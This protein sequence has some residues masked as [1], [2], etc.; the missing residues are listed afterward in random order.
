[1]NCIDPL[2][3]VGTF[4]FQ[5]EFLS[6]IS[7]ERGYRKQNSLFFKASEYS[8]ECLICAKHHAADLLDND[9]WIKMKLHLQN[10]QLTFS[11][12]DTSELSLLALC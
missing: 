3:T 12:Q 1:M 9:E 5:E 8:T 4:C 7:N 2:I 10:H 11:F 6:G